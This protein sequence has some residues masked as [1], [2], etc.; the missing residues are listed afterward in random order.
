M[1]MADSA[2]QNAEI[3]RD[4]LA[5]EINQLL[6]RVNELK[7]DLAKV[8]RFI[9]DWHEFSGDALSRPDV[10]PIP[11]KRATGNPDRKEIA[12]LALD[13]IEARG[14]PVSRNAL[15]ADLENAGI[16]LRGTDPKM[17]LSTM[18]WR[19]MRDGFNLVRLPGF[20]YWFRDRP[21][22]PA[23]YDPATSDGQIS[24]MEPPEGSARFD[25]RSMY[26]LM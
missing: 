7:A 5:S 13:L 4:A 26:K 10:D 18:L 9:S 24:D 25:P 6:Q 23:N 16:A 19:S 11:R 21:Y 14:A 15:F 17:V 2:L 1:D 20:G 22:P 12:K 3:R 8:D